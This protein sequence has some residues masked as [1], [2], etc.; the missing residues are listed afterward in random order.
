MS[1][2]KSRKKK[3]QQRFSH[4]PN[5]C[6]KDDK[7]FSGHT[8]TVPP[9][10]FP[11]QEYL[12]SL[13]SCHTHRHTAVSAAKQRIGKPFLIPLHGYPDTSPGPQPCYTAPFP[14]RGQRGKQNQ[15]PCMT[16]QQRFRHARR[17]SQVS[18][19]LERR[20]GTEKI[21]VQPSPMDGHFRCRLHQPE[22]IP[23]YFSRVS[24]VSK[25]GPHQNL[26]GQAPA[27]TLVSPRQKTFLRR[28][29]QLFLPR[30][31][32]SAGMQLIQMG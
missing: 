15:F 5:R 14:L 30:R 23:H 25:T 4:R 7:A 24:A 2:I 21:G 22:H 3:K 29:A 8:H 31:Y 27:G 32:S 28:V 26:P 19:D 10:H 9:H 12:F 17:I 13:F 11:C 16:L 18:I 20:M 6:K 1:K